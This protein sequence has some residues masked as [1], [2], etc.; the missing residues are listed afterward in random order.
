M[1]KTNNAETVRIIVMGSES[2]F[3]ISNILSLLPL[4]T[5]A[6]EIENGIYS[7]LFT[8]KPRERQVSVENKLF[9][10]TNIVANNA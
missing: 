8:L 4:I 1:P 9:R 7:F 6:S 5:F 3:L 10:L 2:N